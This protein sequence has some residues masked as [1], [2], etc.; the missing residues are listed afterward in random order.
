MRF[1]GPIDPSPGPEQ[2]ITAHQRAGYTAI[3][4]PPFGPD[5]ERLADYLSMAKKAN[6]PIAEVGAWCNPIGPDANESARAMEKCCACLAEAERISARCC[7]NIA[8]SRG[9]NWHGPHPEN[10]SH[11]TFDLIVSTVRKII[12]SVRPARSFYALEAMPWIFPDSPDN[13]LALVK[14]ID[15]KQFAVHLDPVNMINCPARAYRT[16]D[17]LREC[18]A[19]LGPHIVAA[20]A[21]DVHFTQHLTMHLDECRPGT[22]LLDYRTFITEMNRLH[23]D[24]TLALEHLPS[25]E[26]YA[27]AGAYVRQVMTEVAATAQ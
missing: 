2:W 8:G 16:G 9:T 3:A 6:L 27:A 23:P 24:T 20:H 26:E 25:A 5:D 18:F 1:T 14:A 21:K 11:D 13:Y 4:F 10:L 15:R 17:F 22:G 12:D 19:K 7:V